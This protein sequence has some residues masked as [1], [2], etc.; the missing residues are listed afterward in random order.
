MEAP[1]TTRDAAEAISKGIADVAASLNLNTDQIQ[2]LEGAI[3]A[4]LRQGGNRIRHEHE[5]LSG[6]DVVSP[7]DVSDTGNRDEDTGK[8]DD[9]RPGPALSGSRSPRA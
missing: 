4:S 8:L 3:I 2:A 7:E 9:G 6:R 5:Q 1:R